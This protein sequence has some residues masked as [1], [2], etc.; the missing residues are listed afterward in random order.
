MYECI[1]RIG[2]KFQQPVTG[3]AI[4]TDWDHQYHFKEYRRSFM[5]S[6]LVYK[7]NSYVLCDHTP[8]ELSQN[9]NPFAAVMEAAWQYLDRP[10]DDQ[11]LRALKLDLIERLKKRKIPREKI[12]LIVNFIKFFVPFTN[13]EIQANFEQDLITLTNAE[14]PMGLI[15][16]ILED[17]KKQGLQQGIE[18]GREIGIEEGKEIGKEIGVEIGLEI[19]ME[20][21]EAK[22]EETFLHQAV[23]ALLKEGFNAEKIALVLSV[24]LEKVQTVIVQLEDDHTL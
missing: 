18:E 17:V 1:Y 11:A 3:L 2:D 7:F 14:A 8:A 19:G 4:Y 13:S 21:G 23:P 20:I 12:S 9:P 22:R 10:K 15:E 16:A 24:E 6:E 5:G